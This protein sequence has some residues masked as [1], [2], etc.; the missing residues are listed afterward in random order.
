MRSLHLAQVA[1]RRRAARHQL[2]YRVQNG[3][4]GTPE[5]VI[6]RMLHDAMEPVRRVKA[7][8]QSDFKRS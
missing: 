4:D 7:A 6:M 1:R 2:Y 8:L 5:L 3:R